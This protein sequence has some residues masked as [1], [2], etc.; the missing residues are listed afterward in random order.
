MIFNLQFMKTISRISLKRYSTLGQISLKSWTE[1]GASSWKVALR[2]SV[3]NRII[4]ISLS[5]RS[6]GWLSQ[7][8]LIRERTVSLRDP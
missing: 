2:N 3:Y 7:V 4:T 8:N 1:F 6:V 5:S